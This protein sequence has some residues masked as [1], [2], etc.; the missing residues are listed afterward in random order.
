M[1]LIYGFDRI[2]VFQQVQNI[3]TAES[4]EGRFA[5]YFFNI[6]KALVIPAYPAVRSSDRPMKK[7]MAIYRDTLQY[8]KA[9]ITNAFMILK[10]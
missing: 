10:K 2:Y 4:R 1:G 9:G 8:G 3:Y 5:G 7:M 6:I